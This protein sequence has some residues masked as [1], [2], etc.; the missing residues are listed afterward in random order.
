[1]SNCEKKH[2]KEKV[3]LCNEDTY[4]MMNKTKIIHTYCVMYCS[5]KQH[6]RKNKTI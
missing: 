6:I 5:T 4:A 2:M 1:M 3:K